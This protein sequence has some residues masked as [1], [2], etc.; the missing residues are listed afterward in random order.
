MQSRSDEEEM[1]APD[2]V[3]PSAAMTSADNSGVDRVEP[4]LRVTEIEFKDGKATQME[5]PRTIYVAQEKG[6]LSAS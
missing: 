4:D 2:D 5:W 6:I 3:D 1:N